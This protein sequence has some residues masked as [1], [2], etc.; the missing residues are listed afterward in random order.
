MVHQGQ[1][2][3]GH[4]WA[5]VRPRPAAVRP[6]EE[7]IPQVTSDVTM[8]CSHGGDQSSSS[9]Q[10][11]EK[12]DA[13]SCDRCTPDGAAVGCA[14]PPSDEEVWL[15]FND[16]SVTEVKWEEVARES[17]G[18]QQNTSAYCLVYVSGELSNQ[19]CEKGGWEEIGW[20]VM[21]EGGWSLV[22]RMGV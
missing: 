2:S 10:T 6:G 12:G 18:G 21:W 5:Y 14:T 19:W 22:G 1:A 4:Y 9:G 15:K 20:G 3:E 16:V 7:I 11:N 13:A 17:F 8:S